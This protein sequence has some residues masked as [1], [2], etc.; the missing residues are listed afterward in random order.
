[1]DVRIVLDDYSFTITPELRAGRHTIRVENAA[2]QPHHVEF[3]RLA[4]GK[5]VGD[6]MQWFKRREGPP[7]GEP[8]GGTTPLTRGAVSFV[9]ADFAPGEYALFC[10][11]PDAKDKRSHVAHGMVRQ[12]RVE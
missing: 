2:A 4:P 7:P 6:L 8:V 9:T 3:V 11:V 12:I 10:F 5:T 1:V